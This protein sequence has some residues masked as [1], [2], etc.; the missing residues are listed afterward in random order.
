MLTEFLR[1][2]K[3]PVD[4]DRSLSKRK[5]MIRVDGRPSHEVLARIAEVLDADWQL[6]DGK[7]SLVIRSEIARREAEYVKDT[8]NQNWL[9][10]RKS[11]E[12]IQKLRT[13][14]K[15]ELEQRF[16]QLNT[17]REKILKERGENW[18]ERLEEI[19]AEIQ[20]G[21]KFLIENPGILEMLRLSRPLNS[22][23][24]NDLQAQRPV[25][26]GDG[27]LYVDVL[28][29]RYAFWRSGAL[30]TVELGE[31][32]EA[33]EPLDAHWLPLSENTEIFAKIPATVVVPQISG[34]MGDAEWLFRATEKSKVP[35]VMESLRDM[36]WR[37]MAQK[38]IAG[39][40]PLSQLK[41]NGTM[42]KQGDWILIRPEGAALSREDEPEE[43]SIAKIEASESLEL[44]E[45]S[46]LALSL[47]SGQWLSAARGEIPS[48][49]DF[50]L[51][52]EL[53]SPLA[54]WRTLTKQNKDSLKIQRPVPLVEFNAPSG[55]SF[56][57]IIRTAPSGG[58]FRGT[59]ANGQQSSAK[60]DEL[61]YYAERQIK[62]CT[63]LDDGTVRVM[64]DINSVPDS[65]ILDPSRV[66][67]K[68]Q[69][70][71]YTWNFYYGLSPRD[72][73]FYSGS[74]Y[75]NSLPKNWGKIDE[76]A[77]PPKDDGSHGPGY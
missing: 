47:D 67:V 46:R 51:I 24:W 64:G 5:L 50:R 25:K 60:S 36:R 75:W 45:L 32:F 7:Y 1:S 20:N 3:L 59:F 30:V 38:S 76:N 35:I 26:L 8:L 71:E 41:L 72:C 19:D 53:R 65:S 58:S 69:V 77:P 34:V 56:L 44:D 39:R 22:T 18:T 9:E 28:N 73:V 74:T 55:T 2:T 61:F 54:L 10:I 23:D 15:G 66:L 13:W 62:P 12:N 16:R 63:L 68:A 42:Q 33:E 11:L 21:V 48:K 37:S 43:A 17:S 6:Q 49:L 31:S 40:T 29:S 70:Y 14:T 27:E 52:F 4:A 57:E